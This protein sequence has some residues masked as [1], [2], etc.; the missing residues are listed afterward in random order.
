MLVIACVV[1]LSDAVGVSVGLGKVGVWYAGFCDSSPSSR[2]TLSVGL[3][4]VV[5]RPGGNPLGVRRGRCGTSSSVSGL[6][7][8]IGSDDKNDRAQRPPSA[9]IAW[10]PGPSPLPLCLGRP[11]SISSSTADT[12]AAV[13]TWSTESWY[14][15]IFERENPRAC[16]TTGSTIKDVK[17]LVI[18]HR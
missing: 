14:Q 7:S 12:A 11:P 16:R 8:S 18:W 15:L 1:L 5:G 6:S 4:A 17:R 10:N 2:R 13:A 3:V 9:A